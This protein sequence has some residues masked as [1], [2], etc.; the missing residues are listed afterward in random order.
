MKNSFGLSPQRIPVILELPWPQRSGIATKELR[1]S[2]NIDF[3]LPQKHSGSFLYRSA[4]L[5][6]VVGT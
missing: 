1:I 2:D 4:L 5:S 3:Y 6:D